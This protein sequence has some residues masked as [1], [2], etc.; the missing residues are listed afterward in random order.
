MKHDLEDA[1]YNIDPLTGVAGRVGILIKL[2]DQQD[3]MC[4][5]AHF[6]CMAMMDLDLFKAVNDTCGHVV[7]DRI[8]VAVMRHL[9]THTRPYDVIFRYGEEEFLVCLPVADLKT[10]YHILDRLRHQLCRSGRPFT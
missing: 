5:K 1:L 2:C 8:M 7:G 10:G 4:R 3:Y 9:I 6:C